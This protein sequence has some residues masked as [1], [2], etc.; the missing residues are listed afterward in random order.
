MSRISLYR[1]RGKFCF[2]G[3]RFYRLTFGEFAVF[4]SQ[5]IY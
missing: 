5:T 2:D 4:G 1:P 3:D